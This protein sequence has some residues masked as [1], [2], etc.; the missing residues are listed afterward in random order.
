M[1]TRDLVDTMDIPVQGKLILNLGTK[2]LPPKHDH[3]NEVTLAN[4][5]DFSNPP[6]GWQRQDS[7]SD[8]LYFVET[9]TNRTTAVMS[10]EMWAEMLAKYY[11]EPGLPVGWETRKDNYGRTYYVDHNTKTTSWVRPIYHSDGIDS[12]ARDG[13]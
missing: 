3:N 8:R 4:R 9:S 7:E 12:V 5:I 6:E 13:K 1:I 11:K 2:N 10:S